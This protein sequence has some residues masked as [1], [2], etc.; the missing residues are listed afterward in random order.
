ME[1]VIKII[2]YGAALAAAMMLGHWFLA[3]AKRIKAADQPLYKAYFT[4][5]GILILLLV[6][7]AGV[8][9]Y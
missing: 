6:I 5:P 9:W 8:F 2:K 7:A 3:E 1:T 4:I